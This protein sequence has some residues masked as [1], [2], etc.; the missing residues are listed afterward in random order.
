MMHREDIRQRTMEITKNSTKI[1][2]G[3]EK[4]IA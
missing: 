1:E 3:K 4:Q 2:I